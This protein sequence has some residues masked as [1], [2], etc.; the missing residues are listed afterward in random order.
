MQATKET[1]NFQAPDFYQKMGYSVFAAID[2]FGNGYQK[3]YLQKRPE[4]CPAKRKI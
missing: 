3:F 1:S 4:S 2:G